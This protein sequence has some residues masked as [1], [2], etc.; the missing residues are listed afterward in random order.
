MAS[1]AA[2]MDVALLKQ[3]LSR[4]LKVWRTDFVAAHGGRQP[5]KEETKALGLP[6][7]R[8]FALARALIAARRCGTHL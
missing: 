1:V 7:A 6:A 5:T 2:G 3:Q 4:E 8:A